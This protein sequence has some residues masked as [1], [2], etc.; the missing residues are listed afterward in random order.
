MTGNSGRNH[1]PL[2]DG[3]GDQ[4]GMASVG[5][6]LGLRVVS[7][8]VELTGIVAAGIGERKHGTWVKK[9]KS[10]QPRHEELRA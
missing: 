8:G 4:L 2:K 1:I 3:F 5:L 10:P 7:A 6:V 9:R